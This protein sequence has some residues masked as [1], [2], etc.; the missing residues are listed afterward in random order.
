MGLQGHLKS[1]LVKTTSI[2]LV[3]MCPI[4]GE[5]KVQAHQLDQT[6]SA[7]CTLVPKAEFRDNQ[8]KN[9]YHGEL[10][11]PP[12]ELTIN[13]Q[14][15]SIAQPSRKIPS[16]SSARVACPT[17]REEPAIW[18]CCSEQQPI[19]KHPDWFI[20]DKHPWGSRLVL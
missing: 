6:E 2:S 8:G 20:I 11:L 1:N 15:K 10:A 16:K 9:L 5:T 13:R 4:V 12:G 14:T 3:I 7:N 19:E 18:R 17:N